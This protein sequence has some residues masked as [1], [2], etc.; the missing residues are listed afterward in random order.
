MP[1]L[2][3]QFTE[4]SGISLLVEARKCITNAR[5]KLTEVQSGGN[6]IPLWYSRPHFLNTASQMCHTEQGGMEKMSLSQIRPTSNYPVLNMNDCEFQWTIL[7]RW[8]Q[9]QYPNVEDSRNEG[10]G[11]ITLA[12]LASKPWWSFS[13]FSLIT[14]MRYV[15]PICSLNLC[16]VSYWQLFYLLKISYIYIQTNQFPHEAKH[17]TLNQ[18]VLPKCWFCIRGRNL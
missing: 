18:I 8:W 6:R 11:W 15:L 1:L 13:W 14:C 9:R 16:P 10:Q 5:R 2:I 12:A 7:A 4:C 17:G 3:V